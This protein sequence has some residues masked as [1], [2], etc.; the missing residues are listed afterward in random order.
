MDLRQ[1]ISMAAKNKGLE[2]N[3]VGW[4]LDS[5]LSS[6]GAYGLAQLD[7]AVSYHPSIP[8]AQ[9]LTAAE[10]L[11]AWCDVLM[12]VFAPVGADEGQWSFNADK[13]QI[14]ADGVDEA[15]LTVA[16]NAGGYRWVIFDDGG[17]IIADSD[18]G[19]VVDAADDWQ[20]AFSA[21]EADLYVIRLIDVDDGT[22]RQLEIEAV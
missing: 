2:P 3:L 11:A 22:M 14:L 8:P 15:V 16:A 19:G 17:E 13:V 20:L 7:E 18:E 6:N 10:V 9:Y 1:A 21:D 5:G 4:A 12:G